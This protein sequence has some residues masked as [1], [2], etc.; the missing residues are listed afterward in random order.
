MVALLDF[1]HPARDV[2]AVVEDEWDQDLCR[3]N[4]FL[5]DEELLAERFARLRVAEKGGFGERFGGEGEGC[6]R[7]ETTLGDGSGGC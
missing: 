4:A 2:G 7:T 1:A 5:E 6:V 3:F